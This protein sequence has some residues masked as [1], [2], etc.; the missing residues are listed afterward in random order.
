MNVAFPALLVLLLI[1]PGIIVRYAYARGSW[2]WSSPTSFRNASDEL[3]Y[4]VIFAVG[5]HAFALSLAHRLG[6]HADLAALLALLTGSFGRDDERYA[7]TVRAITDHPGAIAT[8]FLSLWFGSALIGNRAHAFVRRFRLDRRFRLLRF[9]NEWWYLLKGEVLEFPESPEYSREPRP[10]SL[11]Y[12]S[13]VVDHA[14]GSYLYRGIVVDWTFDREGQLDTV[15]LIFAHR[16]SLGDDRTNDPSP[17]ERGERGAP[18]DRYYD[19]WGDRFV[20]RYSELR[21]MNLDYFTIT[22]EGSDVAPTNDPGVGL[23]S[24]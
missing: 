24:E 14:S 17:R 12:L 13:T 2:G 18:D 6:H 19:I 4:G 9:R 23:P 8:Y 10:E 20:I 11:V 1:L 7:A 15:V 5:L 21:T 3:A 16:R 22:E